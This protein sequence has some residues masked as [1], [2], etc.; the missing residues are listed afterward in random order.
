MSER[1]SQPATNI[2]IG[3]SLMLVGLLLHYGDSLHLKIFADDIHSWNIIKSNPD[4]HWWNLLGKAYFPELYRPLEL[5][6]VQLSGGASGPTTEIYRIVTLTGHFL[7]GI[8][9]WLLARRLDMTRAVPYAAALLFV[10]HQAA[11]MAV[12]SNDTA[13]QVW[14]TTLGLAG[15]LLLFPR[16]ADETVP[17]RWMPSWSRAIASAA[18]IFIS[19]LW[20][21]AGAGFV[22][23]YGVVM[24]YAV[25]RSENR[26]ACFERL[27]PLLLIFGVYLFLRFNAGVAVPRI[28][29]SS[30]YTIWP[31]INWLR[32]PLLMLMAL[33]TPISTPWIASQY[34]EGHWLAFALAGASSIAYVTVAGVGIVLGVRN[35]PSDR[36]P[37]ILLAICLALSM[38][39]EILTRRVSELYTYKPNV[40]YAPLIA[41]GWVSAYEWMDRQYRKGWIMMVAVALA[42][43]LHVS[44]GTHKQIVLAKN[45]ERTEQLMT[46]LHRQVPAIK[47]P[48][49]VILSDDEADSFQYSVY[50]MRPMELFGGPYTIEYIYGVKPI[51]Y[52]VVSGPTMPDCLAIA[53]QTGPVDCLQIRYTDGAL[54]AELAHVGG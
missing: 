10:F 47:D 34:G 17:D 7:C 51:A 39:P 29:Y 13:S 18:L 27:L 40:F 32:N 28:G 8:L 36:R 54:K 12:L 53:G 3:F 16:D 1:R 14:S 4:I 41:Y 6:L 52:R 37:L 11:T 44:S 9:V 20:K 26:R 33:S 22:F 43:S 50:Q 21:E 19:L 30:R 24:M 35:T 42:L 46:E 15:L 2:Y 25:Y 38:F 49:I 23:I 5:M 45:G 31:G 48:T